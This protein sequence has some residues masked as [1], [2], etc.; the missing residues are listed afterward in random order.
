[1]QELKKLVK[2]LFDGTVLFHKDLQLGDDLDGLKFFDA[3]HSFTVVTCPDDQ[4]TQVSLLGNTFV[5]S[6]D[7]DVDFLNFLDSNFDLQKA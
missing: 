1:M 5:L 3:N 2:E 6:L 4:A 7:Q